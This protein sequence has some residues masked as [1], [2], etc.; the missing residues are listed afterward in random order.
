VL[1]AGA[2]HVRTDRGV[3]I[4]LAALAPDARVL[5]VAFVEVRDDRQ[6]PGSYAE[7][8]G[9]A[10]LPFDFVWFTPRVDDSDP[11]ERFRTAPIRS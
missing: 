2:G 7:R 4:A 1:V 8:F 6:D 3:P 5:S 10:T 9:A 11:C